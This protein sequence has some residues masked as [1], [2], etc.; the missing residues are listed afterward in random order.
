MSVPLR[1]LGPPNSYFCM[2]L[3][4]SGVGWTTTVFFVIGLIGRPVFGSIALVSFGSG[5]MNW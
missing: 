4:I 5:Y 2:Y 1:V 3:Y